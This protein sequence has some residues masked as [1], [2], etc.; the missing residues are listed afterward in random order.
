MQF[1]RHIIMVETQCS[2]TMNSLI[3]DHVSD[4][5]L[6]NPGRSETADTGKEVFWQND[7]FQ[8]FD[9]RGEGAIWGPVPARTCR[10]NHYGLI[11][12]RA[13]FCPNAL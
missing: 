6:R 9:E 3:V 8:P 13:A 1:K 10:K 11:A 4:D 12:L 7:Y 5:Q 2:R